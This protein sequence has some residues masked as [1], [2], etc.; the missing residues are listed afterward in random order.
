MEGGCTES[1]VAKCNGNG[2]GEMG[3]CNTRL[4]FSLSRRDTIFCFSNIGR[5]RRGRCHK[6]DPEVEAEVEEEF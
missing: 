2:S 6:H 3:W 5:R 4:L 1:R